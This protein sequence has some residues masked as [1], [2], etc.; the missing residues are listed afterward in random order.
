M[1]HLKGNNSMAFSTFTVFC[2]QHLYVY[3]SKTFFI[4]PKR[5]PDPLSRHPHHPL[6]PTPGITNLCSVS[7]DLL[8]L[9]TS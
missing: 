6:P 8:I 2:K 5:S 1:N 3:S 7:V 4:T 9:D